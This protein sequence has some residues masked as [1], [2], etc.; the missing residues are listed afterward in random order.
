MPQRVGLDADAVEQLVVTSPFDYERNSLLYC[1][2]EFPD[3][4]SPDFESFVHDE[5]TLLIEAA[6][7][8]TLALFTSNKSLDAAV[9]ALRERVAFPILSA[10]EMSRQALI[11]RFLADEQA[12]IFASQSFFQ[13]VDLP[14]RT[15]SLVVLDKLPFPRP[16]EPLLA[17]RRD[18]LGSG[19]SFG[20]IDLP[21]CATSLAQAAGRLIRTATDAGVVAVLDRRLATQSYWRTLIGAMPPMPRT[22]HRDEVTAFLRR[23][24]DDD[25]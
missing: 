4:R 25:S 15:L 14:G 1:S 10:R 12:C 23:I 7:G 20:E 8:R 11:D 9:A 13:G 6:G 22:R 18:A 21:M 19:R 5:L 16:D 2:P 24:V 17:A 3:R